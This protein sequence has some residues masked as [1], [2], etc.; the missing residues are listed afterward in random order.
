MRRHVLITI[1]AGL[2][3]ATVTARAQKW[4]TNTPLPD[5]YLNHS[6]S[7]ANGFLYN[8][9]GFSASNGEADGTNVFYSPVSRDGT[10]GPWKRTSSL[11]EAVYEHASVALD[12][13]VYVLGGVHYT[14]S[15]GDFFSNTVYYAK[16]N[17]D[18][19]L[20]AWLT[21][22]SLPA[23]YYFHAASAWNHTIFI[24]GGASNTNDGNKTVYSAGIRAD[25]S[26]S[27]WIAQA[28]LPYQIYGHTEAANGI[29]YVLGGDSNGGGGAQIRSNSLYSKIGVDG[30]LTPWNQT[31][32]MPKTLMEFGAVAANG[33]VFV[34]GGWDGTQ[35]AYTSYGATVNGDGTLGT[36]WTGPLLPTELY[37]HAAT[38][39]DSF[40]FVSGGQD[41]VNIYSNVYSMPLPLPPASPILTPQ[42]I[43]NDN[44]Q[45]QLTSSTNTGFDFLAST[46][47][48]NW[49]NIG[50]GFTDTNGVLLFKDTN[51]A[52]FPQRFYRAYWPL[53]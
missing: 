34:M 3:S 33:I 47:L 38:A 14:P 12:G 50:W 20:G 21:T 19:T 31:V 43:T 1:I 52:S 48:M 23:D 36:W 53:P 10:I 51:A 18:G 15:A 2:L 22:T 32:P 40:I 28:P 17:S 29:I 39:S 37:F 30:V 7:Y 42:V 44:F 16:A 5:G 24:T 8:I 11:P 26:L 46:D 13:Y 45:L 35:G 6:L 25:G 49:T 41:I 4:I 27:N 9:G